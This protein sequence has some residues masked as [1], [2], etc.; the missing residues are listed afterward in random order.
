MVTVSTDLYSC[1][2]CLYGGT[3]IDGVNQYSC[4]CAPGYTGSN[5][6]HHINPCESNPC[7]NGA[8]CFNRETGY[9][10]YCPYG[11]TGP[12]CEVRLRALL[13]YMR[14]DC[15]ILRGYV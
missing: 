1:S 12:R 10:C 4:V 5:C 2:S 14:C 11:F 3:C 6:Q 7:I 13:F 9:D 8:T 15:F